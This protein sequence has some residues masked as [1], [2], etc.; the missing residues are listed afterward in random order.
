MPPGDVHGTGMLPTPA[1]GL[2]QVD[3]RDVLERRGIGRSLHSQRMG[4]M[5]Q[6]LQSRPVGTM[7]SSLLEQLSSLVAGR[8]R[9]RVRD[10]LV[11]AGRDGQP[12]DAALELLA[13]AFERYEQ[14]GDRTNAAGIA[15]LL[16]VTG[17]EVE[18]GNFFAKIGVTSRAA[19]T[20]Y[21]Y[22]H[23]LVDP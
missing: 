1:G 4:R 23:Q 11:Q 5:T 14:L 19:A 9:D 12:D 15:L 6:G 8:Q 2:T 22:Q 13:E 10:A 20:A 16:S 7:T 3:E 17:R 21:A 18:V